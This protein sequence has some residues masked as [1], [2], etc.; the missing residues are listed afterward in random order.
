MRPDNPIYDA[1]L[2]RH[3]YTH[4]AWVAHLTDRA[5]FEASVMKDIEAL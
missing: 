5:A 1:L 2:A 4:A 3:D